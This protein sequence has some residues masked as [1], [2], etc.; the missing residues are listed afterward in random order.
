MR[1]ASTPE[2]SAKQAN[3]LRNGLNE[4]KIDAITNKTHRAT[5]KTAP[6]SLKS[7]PSSPKTYRAA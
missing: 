2:I 6:K 7:T 3:R 1:Y 4:L 5:P